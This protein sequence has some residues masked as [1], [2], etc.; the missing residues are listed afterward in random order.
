MLLGMRRVMPEICAA[1]DKLLPVPDALNYMLTGELRNEPT[2]LSTTQLMNV[3]TG[4]V[5]EEV[6]AFFGIKPSLFSP[7]GVH[8][9]RIGFLESGIREELGID[10]E[11]PVVCVPSHDTAAAV[12]AI[13]A[14]EREFAF[15]SSGTWSLIGTELEKPAITEAVLNAGLT[16]EYGAFGRIT[17][18]KNSMGMFMLQRIRAEYE[19]V[20]GRETAWEEI[21]ALMDAHSGEMPLIDVN[22]DAFFN[23]P[24]MSRAVWD[25][26]LDS[27]QAAG[28]IKWPLLIAAVYNSLARSYG[29]A[30]R[31]TEKA[32]GRSFRRIY[33]LGGGANNERLNQ[34]TA[35]RSGK[36]VVACDPESTAL[37]NILCQIKYFDK[38]LSVED[39]RGIAGASIRTKRYTPAG[40]LRSG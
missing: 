12:L 16:N 14:E 9:E 13:P 3:A 1:G 30:V 32:T 2:E 18:L 5:S 21:T 6:C 39:L 28:D 15:I 33:I 8:A 19:A 27:G 24:N 11:I 25:R 17:L 26:L 4:A 34:L 38:D 35:D 7:I 20:T 29:Q 23:P 37:G 36:E 10:Y 22:A 31:D 40:P